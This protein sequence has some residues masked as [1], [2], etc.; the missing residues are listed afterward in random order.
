MPLLLKGSCRCNAVRFEVESHTPVPFML[1]YCSI[2]RKQQG[3]GGFAINLGAD[4]QTLNIRGKRSLGVYRAEIEDDEHPNCEVSTGER[5]FCRKC[6]S[7]LWLYDP[8]WP[9]LVHPF[10]SAID[11]DLPKPPEKV[12]LMLKYKANWVE[13]DI[14]K[15]DK[16]FDVYPE[17]S[18]A[19]WHKRTGMWVE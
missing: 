10:A 9:D 6:G 14:G 5:N 18:I 8:T 2:C 15:G 13:P 4:Y 16:T 11:S 7:A 12:H 19:D 3:G 1:C 17:E